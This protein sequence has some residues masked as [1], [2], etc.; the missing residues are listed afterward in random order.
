MSSSMSKED[1]INKKVALKRKT[2]KKVMQV[3]WQLHV[4]TYKQKEM[5]V[6]KRVTYANEVGH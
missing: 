3:D 1:Y 5:D 2:I 4:R 6:G